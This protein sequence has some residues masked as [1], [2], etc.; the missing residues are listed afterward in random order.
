ME[1]F[2]KMPIK[3][4]LLYLLELLLTVP[5][6]L[7]A[8]SFHEWAH[9]FVAY[10]LGDNTAKYQGR[11][12]VNPFK[13]LDIVGAICMLLCGFGWAKAVP[14]NMLNFKNP[15]RDMAFTALAGPTMNL[16]VGIGGCLIYS[17]ITFFVPNPPNLFVSYLIF[18]VYQFGYLNIF[19][20][21]FNLIPLPPFDGSKILGAFFKDETYLKFMALERYFALGLFALFFLDSRFLGG[22]ISGAISFVVSS[23]FGGL[24]YLFY[25][26]LGLFV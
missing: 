5:T 17:I 8:L 15:K 21:I 22:Y 12:T 13:H 20:A 23:I 1:V 14:V 2:I 4:I 9:A 7:L 16:L 10:K 26:F 18:F 24:Q 19:L 11:L 25:L 6:V 3:E